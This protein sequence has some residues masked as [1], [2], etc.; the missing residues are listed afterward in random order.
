M[1]ER[2]QHSHVKTENLNNVG[3]LRATAFDH[4]DHEDIDCLVARID[5]TNYI[6]E[7]HAYEDGVR[8]TLVSLSPAVVREFAEELTRMANMADAYGQVGQENG[9]KEYTVPQPAWQPNPCL[10]CGPVCGNIRCPN[11]F[12]VSS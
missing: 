2:K 4:Y 5:T 1:Q 11:R 9:I 7:V 8:K 3:T 12:N 10:G 6:V